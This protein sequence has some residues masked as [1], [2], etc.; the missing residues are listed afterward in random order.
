[1]SDAVR[2]YAEE[3]RRLPK[4]VWGQL[5]ELRTKLIEQLLL[6][7]LS[8]SEVHF[9]RGIVAGIDMGINACVEAGKELAED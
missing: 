4:T 7:A 1:M 8:D 6:P 9:R 2:F 5:K 3:D